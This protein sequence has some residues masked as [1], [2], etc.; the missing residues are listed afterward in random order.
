[1]PLRRWL[2]TLDRVR[3]FDSETRGGGRQRGGIDRRPAAGVSPAF[4]V[5]QRTADSLR[6][7]LAAREQTL[8]S[9]R[10]IAASLLPKANIGLR[11]AGATL[12]AC[13]S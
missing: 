3:A 5:K 4:A 11:M 12:P 2:G 13:R 10:E 9:L 6:N 8:S 1:M 7:E